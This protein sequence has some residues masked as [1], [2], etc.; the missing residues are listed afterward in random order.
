MSDRDFGH[1]IHTP[2]LRRHPKVLPL[3]FHPDN[4]GLAAD[5]ALFAGSELGRQNQDQ[6]DVSSLL[7]AGL[8]VK[9]NTVGADVPGLGGVVGTLGGADPRWNAGCDSCA[10]A[11]LGVGFHGL[12]VPTYCTPMLQA[13]REAVLSN[14][15]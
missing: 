11:A 4:G 10:A 8:G 15:R 5:P 14:T 13:G 1:D 2:N 6:L 9:E 7:H 12:G 3:F